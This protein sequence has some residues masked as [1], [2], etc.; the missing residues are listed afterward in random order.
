MIEE[1][2]KY[3]Q[4][5]LGNEKAENYN[6]I[7]HDLISLHSAMACDMSLKLLFLHSHLDFSLK[8]DRCLR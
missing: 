8:H 2:L 4:K 1:E 3:Q 5:F 7:V 6:E